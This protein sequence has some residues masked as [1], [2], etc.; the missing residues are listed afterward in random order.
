[1]LAGAIEEPDGRIHVVATLRADFFDRPLAIATVR[2]VGRSCDGG[3]ATDVAASELEAA[4]V[5]PVSASGAT[6]EPA[7]VAELIAAAVDQP[8]ALPSLQFTLFELADRR[9]DRCLTID[10]YRDLGGLDQAIAARAE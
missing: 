1:M 6:A 10:D 5:R 8:V 7:L 4:I 9:A 2:S 3:G